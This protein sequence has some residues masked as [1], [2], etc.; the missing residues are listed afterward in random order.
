MKKEASH[1]TLRSSWNN[2]VGGRSGW[3]AISPF[4]PPVTLS[5]SQVFSK[6]CHFLIKHT[7]QELRHSECSVNVGTDDIGRGEGAGTSVFPILLSLVYLENPRCFMDSKGTNQS[8]YVQYS[9]Y[10]PL[11]PTSVYSN[12]LLF[13]VVLTLCDAMDCS[14][15]GLH[16]S[17]HLLKF[18]QVHVH[19]IGH[20]VQPS[21]LL[22][23]SSP[24][25]PNLSQHHGI[26]Q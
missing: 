7:T 26:F 6:Q 12:L 16:V 10:D 20:A 15:P 1:L 5:I 17:H 14:T 13:P 2:M 11:T 18:A 24:S 19:C 25:A 9:K 3:T 8:K 22:T 23:P 21:H 4:S